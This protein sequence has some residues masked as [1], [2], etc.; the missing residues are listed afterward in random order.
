MSRLQRRLVLSLALNFHQKRLQTRRAG[1][2][3]A[4]TQRAG[5]NDKLTQI[6][7]SLNKQPNVGELESNQ[8]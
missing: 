7:I 6:D 4:T 5:M 8:R 1:R 2:T 3:D